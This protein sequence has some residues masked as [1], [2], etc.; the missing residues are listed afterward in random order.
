MTIH[1]V[2]KISI[3]WWYAKRC[4][5]LNEYFVFQRETGSQSEGLTRS[6]PNSTVCVAVGIIRASGLQVYYHKSLSVCLSV[7]VLYGPLDYRYITISLRLSVCLDLSVRFVRLSTFQHTVTCI[8]VF[9]TEWS[10]LILVCVII[11]DVI[12]VSVFE[13]FNLWCLDVYF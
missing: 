10:Q 5:L 3:F 7:S 4:V 1:I 13:S 11:W 6:Q 2:K 8:F 12:F 9:L